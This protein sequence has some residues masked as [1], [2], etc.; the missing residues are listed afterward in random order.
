MLYGKFNNV[1]SIC[2]ESVWSCI[3]TCRI[4]FDGRTGKCQKPSDETCLGSPITYKY[5]NDFV[6][7]DLIES[8]SVLSQYPDCWKYMKPLLCSIAYRPCSIRQYFY[9]GMSSNEDG[10]IESWQVFQKR[11]CMNAKDRCK[12]LIDE[13]LWPDFLKCDD[14]VRPEVYIT[15]ESFANYERYLFVNNTLCK[16]SYESLTLN[17][18]IDEKN[19]C[20]WPLVKKNYTKNS[21]EAGTSM[22]DNCHIP[23]K[24]SFFSNN[25]IY[26][27]FQW[28]VGIFTGIILTLAISVLLYIVTY[29]QVFQSSFIMFL[30]L[31]FLSSNVL[32][33]SLYFF[34]TT[35]ILSTKASCLDD[36]SIRKNSYYLSSVNFDSCI[37]QGTLLQICINSSYL[38]I[39]FIVFCHYAHP[40]FCFN[41]YIL[42]GARSGHV[43]ASR[44]SSKL[45]YIAINLIVSVLLCLFINLSGSISS[46]GVFQLCNVGSLSFKSA[47]N[48]YYPI[49]ILIFTTISIPMVIIIRRS[50]SLRM[51]KNR[52][53]NKKHRPLFAKMGVVSSWISENIEFQQNRKNLDKELGSLDTLNFN[54]LVFWK[55]DE[56]LMIGIIVIMVLSC[57][58]SMSLH[59]RI[60]F[61][62]LY[63]ENEIKK[64]HSC[65]MNKYIVGGETF[66]NNSI[67]YENNFFSD[68]NDPLIRKEQIEH[69]T[70]S[71]FEGC[72]NFQLIDS[73][74]PI[75]FL[76]YII[77]IPSPFYIILI[78]AIIGVFSE[79]YGLN[80]LTRRKCKNNKY[81]ERKIIRDCEHLKE[82]IIST[83][84]L[85]VR[86][87]SELLSPSE[88][89]GNLYP[90]TNLKNIH[91]GYSSLEVDSDEKDNNKHNVNNVHL[92]KSSRTVNKGKNNSSNESL[93]KNSSKNTTP[94]DFVNSTTQETDSNNS[95]S[96]D[97]NSS[98]ASQYSER[99]KA[100]MATT[101][102]NSS[103]TNEEKLSVIQEMYKNHYN[104]FF[105]D[106][107]SSMI[108]KE[109]LDMYITPEMEGMGINSPFNYDYNS[110]EKSVV[111]Y[112]LYKS[113]IL[114]IQP[115]LLHP[116]YNPSQ[117]MFILWLQ[118][119]ATSPEKREHFIK[120]DI[121]LFIRYKGKYVWVE[122]PQAY[123]DDRIERSE[124]DIFITPNDPPKNPFHIK[125]DC[126]T[127]LD[128]QKVQLNPVQLCLFIHERP[129]IFSRHY[130][131]N[132][133]DPN[134]HYEMVRFYFPNN[135]LYVAYEDQ[136]KLDM[137]L[138]NAQELC[139]SKLSK[140]S[141]NPFGS[142][143][144]LLLHFLES[145]H[146]FYEY[147]PK[148]Y[149][150]L[151][152]YDVDPHTRWLYF[153][154][155]I[156]DHLK[157]FF[158]DVEG[159][160]IESD[161]DTP[162]DPEHKLT[163]KRKR[164]IQAVTEDPSLL[165]NL[166]LENN[167]QAFIHGH[168]VSILK[169]AL[170]ILI[171]DNDPFK[172]DVIP[173]VCQK[174]LALESQYLFFKDSG[175]DIVENQFIR[176]FNALETYIPK[177][178][179][180]R[181]PMLKKFFNEVDKFRRMGP[182]GELFE[183][184]FGVGNNYFKH[185]VEVPFMFLNQPMN[186][187]INALLDQNNENDDE[188]DGNGYNFDDEEVYE[189]EEIDEEEEEFEL[190]SESEND[191]DD[192]FESGENSD[193]DNEV[194]QPMVLEPIQEIDNEN[195]NI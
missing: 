143:Y 133:N 123:N 29:T 46:S 192:G 74:L 100:T 70:K 34:S 41:H 30:V 87:E 170:E 26:T 3:P 165:Y 124:Y 126:P 8:Y 140:E 89:Y 191:S 150:D 75:N 149:G 109:D 38:T 103:L 82:K 127:C 193:G 106:N 45:L 53:I 190:V 17:E 101:G 9:E 118:Y 111:F 15:E 144:H 77:L 148:Y 105:K 62:E 185:E 171:S 65:I 161:F 88:Q 177:A 64:L 50:I 18:N 141:L 31:S 25:F 52:E 183:D 67:F 195:E 21:I 85:D 166:K 83:V 94:T 23:C 158:V 90:I 27:I 37:F 36:S 117:M 137:V 164:W 24:N 39:A 81:C 131:K 147:C 182:G 134:N 43:L 102:F 93:I 138:T 119:E 163:M 112:P 179:V 58:I 33:F 159:F 32:Y 51:I 187:N 181:N 168:D 98:N 59:V 60:G 48:M 115:S 55:I 172:K 173:R 61:D 186:Y 28:S 129:H 110:L 128:D 116:G 91:E 120:P 84:E 72:D 79:Y 4:Q 47:L 56:K 136:E 142:N 130:P 40:K 125:F 107:S 54:D 1:K 2:N 20:M 7:K 68:N 92:K 14:S 80:G 174:F 155:R 19:Q 145:C 44:I 113:Q 188:N 152:E 99:T 135:R 22:I 108:S 162:I 132:A 11:S 175:N 154:S 63:E 69:N 78:S 157:E 6:S 178:V 97:E 76:I 180:A 156:Y 10:V 5:V 160:S 194:I 12:M 167:H 86:E 57:A 66:Q 139:E 114:P 35:S 121:P 73:L 42:L 96:D 151:S 95:C 184:I 169:D 189:E 49:I 104:M 153:K 13:N 146:V 122:P 16:A 176:I 71:F